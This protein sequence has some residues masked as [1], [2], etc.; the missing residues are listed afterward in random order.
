MLGIGSFLFVTK[1]FPHIICVVLTLIN[2][3]VVFFLYNGATH[4]S[5]AYASLYLVEYRFEN[6]S[7]IFA[8]I[9]SQYAA[10]HDGAALQ[11][12]SLKVG[13]MG[14]C[15]TFGDASLDSQGQDGHVCGYTSDIVSAY[16]T[17]VP[18]FSLT[19]SNS[20]NAAGLELFD[21]AQNFQSKVMHKVVFVVLLI[22]LLALLVL[23]IYSLLAFL[24]LQLYVSL[25]IIST[26]FS[27]F[28]ILCIVITW[29]LVAD[30]TLVNTGY[31][32]SLK[33]LLV[34]SN[35]KPQS[36]LWALFAL[37]IVEAAFHIWKLLGTKSPS[38]PNSDFEKDPPLAYSYGYHPQAYVHNPTKHY[39]HAPSGSVMSSISTLRGVL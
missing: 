24:P 19:N 18:S 33:I 20:T 35:K 15:L 4:N 10:Q 29:L 3:A 12:F 22:F 8:M 21:L 16:S 6:K 2:V 25:L 34:S 28:V 36:L 1:R 9:E 31:E 17:D 30:S 7:D 14:L 38:N 23:Q 39:T 32:T 5:N 11:D 26:I 13:Y 27:C 37:L